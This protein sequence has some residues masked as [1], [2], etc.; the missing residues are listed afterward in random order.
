MHFYYTFT[1]C[2]T[3]LLAKRSVALLNSKQAI[4]VE[5]KC[6][7]ATCYM[8]N[9]ISN[10]WRKCQDPVH[11]S[12]S[13]LLYLCIL[14]LAESYAPEPNPGPRTP[15]FPC[16]ICSKACKW[17]TPCVC[18]DSCDIW[19]HQECLNMPNEIFTALCDISWECAKCGLPNFSSG[20]FDTTLFESCNNS[21]QSNQGSET[22][23]GSPIAT[24]SPKTQAPENLTRTVPHD[25]R[26]DL[27]LKVLVINCQSIKTP[28]KKGSLENIITTSNANIVIG[29]ESWL[30]GSINSNEVFPEGYKAYR[31]DRNKNGGGVFILTSQNLESRELELPDR[32]DAEM[33]WIQV[34]IKGAKDLYIGSFYRPPS[35]IQPTYLEDIRTV[36]KDIP[37]GAHIWLAGDFNLGD[38]DWTHD[39]P[40]PQASNS[41]Q[42][43]QILEI[44]R[45]FFLEQ[46]VT[47]PT[48]VTEYTSTILDLFFTNNSTL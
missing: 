14:L 1:I 27:P 42:C 3:L 18:C 35:K 41:V 46:M 12:K 2:A 30:D 39:T 37:A 19:F 16:G 24:S 32:L 13:V 48:R 15:K 26:K 28:G 21:T 6:H 44:A 7:P 47:S 20:L 33:I 11:R 43:N 38:I 8:V 40:K 34:K 45:E 36:M 29:N 17:T 9:L 5:N 10:G 31:K 23:F 22:C 4:D 25:Q